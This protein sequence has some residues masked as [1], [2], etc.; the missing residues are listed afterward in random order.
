MIAPRKTPSPAQ[1]REIARA[2]ARARVA[3]KRAVKLPTARERKAALD[4]SILGI[5]QKLEKDAKKAYQALDEA[6]K[7]RVTRAAKAFFKALGIAL[8]PELLLPLS[9]SKKTPRKTP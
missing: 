4:S 6:G 5:L 7:A 2:K 8:P 3:G 9:P 1:I